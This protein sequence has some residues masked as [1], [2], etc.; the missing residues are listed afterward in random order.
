[1]NNL[2]ACKKLANIVIRQKA[3]VAVISMFVIMLFFETNFYTSF[4]LL[5]L[6][7]SSS[8]FMILAFGMTVVIIAEG[9]DLSVGGVLV[10]S[11]IVTI[12]LMDYA[13]IWLSILGG[14]SVGLVVGGLNGFLIVYKKK[15]PLVITLGM[16]MLLTGLAQQLTDAHPIAAKDFRFMMI[17]NSRI[18]NTI[19][20]LVVIMS[21]V[22]A[23]IYYI[24]RYTQFGRNIYAIG[25]DYEVA[26]YSG[27]N[28]L[29]IKAMAYVICSLTAALGGILLSSKLNSGS[30]LYGDTSALIVICGVVVG[31]TSLEGGMGGV[32]LTAM[33]LLVFGV[34]EN[35]MNMLGINPYLQ[36]IFSGMLIVTILFL[37]S[38]TRKRKREAV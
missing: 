24:L 25:G 38:Y 29:R 7:N 1:M 4:N 10:V 11:G 37:D 35:S 17:A 23:L 30:A 33:G 28:V 19:P 5:D 12:Q 8:I 20:T 36:M 21:V 34:M 22:F 2:N 18:F 3:T 26:E 15:E 14:I 16:G 31:G 13:P 6:L 32:F 9:F 27:I